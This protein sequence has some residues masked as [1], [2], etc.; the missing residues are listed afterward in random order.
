MNFLGT[1]IAFAF[2]SHFSTMGFSVIGEGD[3][4]GIM[5]ISNVKQKIAKD[6]K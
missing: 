6:R 1:N 5:K 3:S 4:S 2:D